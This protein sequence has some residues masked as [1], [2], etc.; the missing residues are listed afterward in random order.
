MIC[1]IATTKRFDDPIFV[2]NFEFFLFRSA[3]DTLVI[4]EVSQRSI[5]AIKKKMGDRFKDLEVPDQE[6]S[7]TA[8]ITPATKAAIE[9]CLAG[10]K[11]E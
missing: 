7:L 6:H 5:Q 10:W 11:E 4:P 1:L 2:L 8:Q 3:Q 9:T